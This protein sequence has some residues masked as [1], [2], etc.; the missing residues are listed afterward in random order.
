VEILIFSWQTKPGDCWYFIDAGMNG[1]NG[2]GAMKT[3][4]GLV[5]A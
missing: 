5:I 4:G 1:V 2:A 3:A